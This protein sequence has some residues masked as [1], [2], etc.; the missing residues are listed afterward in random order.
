[1]E[2]LESY[3]NDLDIMTK[4]LRQLRKDL[5]EIAGH[6]NGDNPGQQEDDARIA[7]EVIEKIKEINELL[8]FE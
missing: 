6:W 8:S 5:E 3:L 2:T 7:I 4:T 1:M